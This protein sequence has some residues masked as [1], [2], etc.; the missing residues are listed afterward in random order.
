MSEK[1]LSPSRRDF[2]KTTSAVA[3]AAVLGGLAALRS[4]HAAGSDVLRVGLIGCGGRG[5]ARRVNA[6]GAD[7]NC[8]LVAMADA[9]EDRL[10]GSLDQLKLNKPATR[11]PSIPTI[12]SSASTPRTSC[13]QAA[14]TWCFS[15]SRRTFAPALEGRRRRRQTRLLRETGRRRRPRRA[16]RAG[17]RRGGEEKEAEPRLPGCA[18]DTIPASARR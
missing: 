8:K 17:Y 7:P 9:F 13:L 5:A 16:Q 3:A 10:K 15:P 6:L 12:A 4:V 1:R 2:L 11:S 14:W 18:G